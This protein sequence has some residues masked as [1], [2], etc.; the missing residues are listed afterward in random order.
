MDGILIREIIIRPNANFFSGLIAR[1]AINPAV[2]RLACVDNAVRVNRHRDMMPG[3]KVDITAFP[4]FTTFHKTGVFQLFA[5]ISCGT[6]LTDWKPSFC[7]C[8]S[9]K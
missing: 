5:E 2:F 3:R 7:K 1:L 9:D 6:V 4:R 8:R